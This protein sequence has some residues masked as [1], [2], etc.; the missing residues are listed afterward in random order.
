M[1]ERVKCVHGVAEKL[2]SEEGTEGLQAQIM[3]IR[4]N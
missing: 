3:E 4:I 2:I 1:A